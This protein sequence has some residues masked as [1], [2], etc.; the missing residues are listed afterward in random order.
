[1]ASASGLSGF[2]RFDEARQRHRHRIPLGP[3]LRAGDQRL[4][5]VV[6]LT[7]SP[8]T[9][10]EPSVNFNNGSDNRSAAHGCSDAFTAWKPIDNTPPSAIL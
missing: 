6:S 9:S 10:P 4:G 7:T 2:R 3:S 5:F 1:L 8:R